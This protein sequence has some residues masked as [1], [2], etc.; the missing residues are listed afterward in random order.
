MRALGLISFPSFFSFPS[1]Y[2]AA[3]HER[4][5]SAAEV[6]VRAVTLAVR[7]E[8][9]LSVIVLDLLDLLW[10][11]R[12]LLKRWATSAWS[13]SAAAHLSLLLHLHL[14]GALVC[15]LD[16]VRVVVSAC[17]VRGQERGSK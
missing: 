10:R 17:V 11:L 3:A 15:A 5:F 1:F 9:V 6:A 8:I 7:A 16:A 4:T 2:H 13:L 12:H 14:L